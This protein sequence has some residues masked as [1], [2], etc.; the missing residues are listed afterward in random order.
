[1][2]DM[3]IRIFEN[4]YTVILIRQGCLFYLILRRVSFL[5]WFFDMK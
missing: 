2:F 5:S 3:L 1:M 4:A